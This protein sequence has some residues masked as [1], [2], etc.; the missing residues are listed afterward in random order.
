MSSRKRLA[1]IF[2]RGGSKGVP[3]KNIKNLGGIPLIAH[4]IKTAQESSLVEQIIVSTDDEH[5][6]NIAIKYGA[7]VPFMR[8][9]NLAE[10]TSIELDAWKHA[11][12]E[13]DAHFDTFIS[14]PPTSPLRSVD[15]IEKCIYEYENTDAD[16]VLT[17]KEA[18]RNPFFNMVKLDTNEYASLVN[19]AR[20]GEVFARRQDTP[21]IYDMTTVAYVCNPTFVLEMEHLFSGRTRCVLIPDYR[22]VDIDTELDFEFAEFLL[23]GNTT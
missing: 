16:L 20:N 6:A 18:S 4:T 7:S 21:K 11:V 22:A 10:D 3:G 2:A 8:P 12:E 9:Q 13:L 15:D 17:V 14:L 1:F 5:I 23:K 19:K